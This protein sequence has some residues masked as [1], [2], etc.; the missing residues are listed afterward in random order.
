[1]NP[2]F[3]VGDILIQKSINQKE[4]DIFQIIKIESIKSL[5]FVKVLYANDTFHKYMLINN[6][7]LTYNIE[8]IDFG[9]I[10]WNK[11]DYLT[12]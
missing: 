2:K 4:Y 9:N 1:M 6:K 11:A 3:K 12:D 8:D 5:Y 10:Y 7:I